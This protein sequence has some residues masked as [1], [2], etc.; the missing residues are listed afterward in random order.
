MIIAFWAVV[1]V[2]L[3]GHLITTLSLKK[4]TIL[5]MFIVICFIYIFNSPIFDIL[6]AYTRLDGLK[7]GSMSFSSI[8]SRTEMMGLFPEQLNV[9]PIFGHF[10]AQ[11]MAGHPIGAYAHSIPP[12][13]V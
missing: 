10:R 8:S 2:T 7:D 5:L 9:S 6:V 4:L 12:F 11:V 1:A 3:F 13:F